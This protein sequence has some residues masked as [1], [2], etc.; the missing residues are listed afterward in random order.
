MPDNFD[1]L[2]KLFEKSVRLNPINNLQFTF[3]EKYVAAMNNNGQIGV[4]ATLNVK[5][6][7]KVIGNIDLSKV[8]CRVAA[9]AFV[10]ASLNYLAK[11]DGYGDIF[12]V[13]DFTRFT[14]PVMIGYF[15][16]LVQKLQ[17]KGVSPVVFDIDQHE[18]PVLPMEK[19]HEYLMQANCVIL[20]STSISNGTFG[21]IAQAVS[22]KCSIYMLGPSTPLDDLMFTLPQVKGLFG[23]IFPL[24]SAET[25]NLIAQGYGT[26]GF[27]HTMQKVYR[28]RK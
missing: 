13:V 19:Q 2:E 20:T 1:I 23:S 18:A 10:N 7:P 27:M 25:L 22:P 5:V 9:N 3:G 15:G 16:S 21:G 26:W 28:I 11:P 12:D 4:C 24:H 6:H 8:E 14:N 17:G